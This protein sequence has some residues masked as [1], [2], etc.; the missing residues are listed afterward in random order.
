MVAQRQVE[1]RFATQ[2][3]GNYNNPLIGGS[4][5]LNI[6]YIEAYSFILIISMDLKM[7]MYIY[8]Y[9]NVR[10]M[11]ICVYIVSFY[12]QVESFISIN[13]ESRSEIKIYRKCVLISLNISNF[14]QQLWHMVILHIILVNYLQTNLWKMLNLK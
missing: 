10:M 12:V 2:K 5:L 14:T 11:Y 8:F 7:K 4:C 3:I 9:N 13:N 1:S 6:S